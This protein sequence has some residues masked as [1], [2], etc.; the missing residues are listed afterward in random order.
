MNTTIFK[1]ISETIKM[2]AVRVRR[3]KKAQVHS[4]PSY[5]WYR[6]GL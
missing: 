4:Y 2:N 6:K 3:R 5:R 1:K